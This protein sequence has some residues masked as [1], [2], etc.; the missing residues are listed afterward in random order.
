M[1]ETS[2][3][4]EEASVVSNQVSFKSV[5]KHPKNSIALNILN[6]DA[7]QFN[8][9]KNPVLREG[10][11]KIRVNVTRNRIRGKPIILLLD[12]LARYVQKQVSKNSMLRKARSDLVLETC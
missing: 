2:S 12:N 7:K 6:R 9:A 5:S 8:I 1:Y 11:A 3:A 4:E 10:T